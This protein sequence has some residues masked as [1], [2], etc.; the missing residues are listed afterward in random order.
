MSGQR[1]YYQVLGVPRDADAKAIKN[2]FRRLAR[3]YH[4]D[5]SS[6]PDAAESFTEIAEAYGVLSD[7]ARRASY[8]AGG[9]ARVAGATPQDLWAGIDFADIFGA[10][11]PGFGGGLFER[12][13]GP[14]RAGPPRGDDINVEAIISLQQVL[15]GTRQAVTITCPGRCPHCSGSDA[16]PGTTPRGCPD[17]GGTRCAAC[18]LD[19][20][21]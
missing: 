1:D 11:A 20:T 8:N 3:R 10:G 19:Q 15:T 16:R 4:P 18:I 6:E 21:V 2:A 17:C 14:A 5:T 12:L 13:F 9:F 7:P